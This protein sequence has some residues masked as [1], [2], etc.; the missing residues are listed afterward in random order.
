MFPSDYRPGQV[1]LKQGD[2][3]DFICILYSGKVNVLSNEISVSQ[4]LKDA[5]FH[6]CSLD[7][8]PTKIETT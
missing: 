4:A 2:K 6:V 7:H 3:A 1:I 8:T 5:N